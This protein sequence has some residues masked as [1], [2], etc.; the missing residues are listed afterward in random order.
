MEG[1][2]ATLD[3]LTRADIQRF[4]QS[5]YRPNNAQ[6]TI[7]GQ[8]SLEEAAGILEKGLGGWQAAPIKKTP[9][10]PP[11]ELTRPEVVKIDRSS[12][13]A[14]ILWGHLGVKPGGIPTITPCWS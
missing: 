3:K 4:F 1:S 8:I 13:Q 10:A 6:V 12:S 9:P 7:V 2:V 11:Q 14:N 5:Y